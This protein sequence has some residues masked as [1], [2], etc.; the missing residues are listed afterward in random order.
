MKKLFLFAVIGLLFPI[1]V[2]GLSAECAVVMD[3]DSGRVLYEK[4][5]D[6]SKLIASTTKIMT[7]VIA[8]EYGELDDIVMIDESVLKAYGSAIYVEIGEELTLKELLYGLMLRSGNDAAIAIAEHVSG[9]MEG[10]VFLMNQKA[11]ELGMNN[12][13]FYNDHGLE[14]ND[15]KGNTSTAY[16]MA[17]LMRYA[18]TIDEFRSITSTKEITV[19]SSYKTYIWPNKNKLLKMYEYTTGGKTGYTEKAKR[20]LVTSATKDGKNL[21]VV[22]LNDGDDFNDHMN[23]YE[24]YFNN[25]QIATVIDKDNLVINDD[26]YEGNLFVNNSFKMLVSKDE[27]KDVNTNVVLD[28]LDYYEDGDYI[29]YIEVRIGKE[30]INKENVYVRKDKQLIK[31]EKKSFWSRV[32]DYLFFW[33]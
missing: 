31:E 1:K 30:V 5:M 2:L 18:N 23:L 25:Y 7:A 14:E 22:T 29:G 32:L 4:N 33:K 6:K 16:D 20:T 15:G 13:I 10:F 27:L 24:E 8:I 12:T 26:Y 9:S 28:K 11:E 3:Q 19:K 17:L 21:I